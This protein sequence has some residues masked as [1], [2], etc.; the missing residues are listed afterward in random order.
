M[1]VYATRVDGLFLFLTAP[2]ALGWTAAFVAMLKL[3][4]SVEVLAD[5]LTARPD[6]PP[7]VSVV[8]PACDEAASVEAS[9]RSW[10]EQEDVA[11]QIVVVDDRS[12]DGTGAILDRLAEE[13]PRVTVVHVDE[14]PSGWLGKVHALHRGVAGA[15]G[16]WLLFADADVALAPDA[17]A[18]AVSHAE[19]KGTDLLTAIPEVESADFW[20]DV[21]WSCLGATTGMARLWRTRDPR[22][23]SAFGAGAFILVRRTA[24]EQTPGFPWLRL[25]VADDQGLALLLKSNG[26]RCDIVNGRGLVRLAWYTSLRDMVVRSQKN[27]FCIVGR[28]ALWRCL[29]LAALLVAVALSPFA[30]LLPG[31]TPTLWAVPLVGQAAF[32]GAAALQAW[33]S[34]RPLLPVLFAPLGLLL[35]AIMIVRSGLLGHRLGGIEWRGVLYRSEALRGL[36]RFRM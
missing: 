31:V 32:L 16:Q 1:V 8:S 20:S 36:Q 21:V 13:D 33:W 6:T 23:E 28:F 4:R 12:T 30:I 22:S 26:F 19:A 2:T 34:R 25:E 24:F 35:V 10:L 5:V 29:L 11:L 9:V 27:W 14:L 17:L 18:R 15:E 7:R 3:M